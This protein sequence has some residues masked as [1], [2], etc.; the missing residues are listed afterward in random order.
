MSSTF[1]IRSARFLSTKIHVESD[2]DTKFK[3]ILLLMGGILHGSYAYVTKT[4]DTIKIESTY[5][6]TYSGFTHFM[7]VDTDGVHY[8]V[9]NSLWFWKFD[10]IEDWKKLQPG[11]KIKIKKYGFRMP[12]FGIFPR[13]VKSTKVE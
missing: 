9:G 6:Y 4:N 11:Q 8:D 7:A 13:I 10:S 1:L 2:E 12:I 3:L 5:K